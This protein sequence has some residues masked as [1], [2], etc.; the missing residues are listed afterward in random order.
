MGKKRRILL[1]AK[2][3]LRSSQQVSQGKLSL[4]ISS[5]TGYIGNHLL[6]AGCTKDLR[7]AFVVCDINSKCCNIQV[8]CTE[9][10]SISLPNFIIQI[11][12]FHLNEKDFDIS[13]LLTLNFSALF[14]NK[15]QNGFFRAY[16]NAKIHQYIHSIVNIFLKKIRKFYI[17]LNITHR[18][19]RTLLA[20]YQVASG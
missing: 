10:A 8:K 1:V 15:N 19:I 5:I 7:I 14:Y 17:R 13:T 9:M 11:A 3:E 16:Y 18:K 20:E 2:K 6:N 4:S 12:L